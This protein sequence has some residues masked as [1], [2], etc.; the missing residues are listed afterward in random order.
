VAVRTRWNA[1]DPNDE[2]SPLIV[3]REDLHALR[4]EVERLREALA[5]RDEQV[6][7]WHG[8]ALRLAGEVGKRA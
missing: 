7:H 6:N 2:H 4:A 1:L 8:E 3:P 5:E